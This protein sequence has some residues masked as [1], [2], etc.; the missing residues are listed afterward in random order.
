MFDTLKKIFK[1]YERVFLHLLRNPV[2]IRYPE[3]RLIFYPGFRGRHLLDLDTCIG[4]GLCARICPA[5]AIEM[6]PLEGRERPTVKID[7][8]K[9]VY[10]GL[11]VDTCPRKALTNTDLVEISSYER[12]DLVYPPKR[13]T[14]KPK[15]EEILPMLK[16][17]IRPK[18]V[19]SHVVY[20]E[21]EE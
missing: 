7:Y 4:C 2:T 21:V 11:C 9:C 5:N 3:E 13:L 15:I 12:E 18:I 1:P 10:C 16:R 14:E 19:G 17:R 20:E 6:V 8:G